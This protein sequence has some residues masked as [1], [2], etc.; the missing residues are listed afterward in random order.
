MTEGYKPGT[1]CIDIHCPRHKELEQ[2]EGDAYLEKKKKYC[3]DCL[4][5][6]FFIWLGEREFRIIKTFDEIPAKELAA[7]LKGI[8]PVRVEHLTVEEILCL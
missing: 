1:F 4:A 3:K 8:D 6:K 5:W 7:R 2:L